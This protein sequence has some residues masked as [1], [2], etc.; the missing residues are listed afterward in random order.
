MYEEC[1]MMFNAGF[2]LKNFKH[3][4]FYTFATRILRRLF[5]GSEY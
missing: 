2:T 3:Y 4:S 1:N 5:I